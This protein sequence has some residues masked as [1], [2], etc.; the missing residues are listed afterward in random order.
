[1]PVLEKDDKGPIMIASY[2]T[3]VKC[4]VYRLDGFGK[5]CLMETVDPEL[6]PKA[7][8]TGY[9]QTLRNGFMEV[10]FVTVRSMVGV[11]MLVC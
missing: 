11:L 5:L 9:V 4:F 2:L 10:E 1:M 3:R 8:T 7:R 6:I